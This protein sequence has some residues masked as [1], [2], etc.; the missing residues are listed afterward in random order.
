MS[1]TRPLVD[2]PADVTPDSVDPSLRIDPFRRR[3]RWTSFFAAAANRQHTLL[4]ESSVS[5]P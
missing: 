3:L 5:C 4:L 2:C 1:M